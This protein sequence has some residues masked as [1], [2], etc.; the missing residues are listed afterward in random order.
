MRCVGQT[1]HSIA[2]AP[3]RGRTGPLHSIRKARRQSHARRRN[4]CA[5]VHPGGSRTLC[6]A[7]DACTNESAKRVEPHPVFGPAE[8]NHRRHADRLSP[9]HASKSCSGAVAD[10]TMFD[11]GNRV[12]IGFCNKPA[13]RPHFQIVHQR[14]RRPIPQIAPI[15]PSARGKLSI[16]SGE[17][18]MGG[19]PP[20][21]GTA[22]RFFA[23]VPSIF[24]HRQA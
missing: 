24:T 3:A 5:R 9:S 12:G 15:S 11:N 2:H 1:S 18:T 20:Q 16:S 17:D 7:L 8:R 10:H 6:R 21:R 14:N 13:F 22:S 19:V 4:P 23:Q